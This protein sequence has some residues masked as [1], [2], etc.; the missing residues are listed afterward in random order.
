[1]IY[2]G[3]DMNNLNDIRQIDS[4]FQDVLKVIRN[5]PQARPSARNFRQEYNA[6]INQ[7]VQLTELIN[8]LNNKLLS[9]GISEK[10]KSDI[11]KKI[12]EYNQIWVYYLKTRKNWKKFKCNKVTK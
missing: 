1:M 7:S 3:N 6:I 5:A 8:N 11:R 9:P 10:E 2:G 12:S 4:E